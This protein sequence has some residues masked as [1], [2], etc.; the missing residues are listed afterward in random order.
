MPKQVV[1][2][3]YSCLRPHTLFFI[4]LSKYCQTLGGL[5]EGQPGG[6]ICRSE[7]RLQPDSQMAEISASVCY[8]SAGS[9]CLGLIFCSIK[10]TFIRSSELLYGGQHPILR[11]LKRHRTWKGTCGAV[12]PNDR[13]LRVS[14]KRSFY[15]ILAGLFGFRGLQRRAST[16]LNLS[17]TSQFQLRPAEVY[18]K[19]LL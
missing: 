18:S 7:Q 4:L 15:S 16:S 17:Q 2:L 5:P 1:G 13:R 8:I 12:N 14:A 9:V 11:R 3:C 19:E 6:H 10:S